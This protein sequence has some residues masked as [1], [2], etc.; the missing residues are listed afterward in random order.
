ME[1]AWYVRGM[2][3]RA[4]PS[5]DDG[6]LVLLDAMLTGNPSDAIVRSEA[7]GQ[8]ELCESESLPS[9]WC[10]YREPSPEHDALLTGLGF[11]LGEPFP[12]DPLFRPCKLPE[13]WRI[14]PT[15]H[16]M[17]SDIVDPR[18]FARFGVFY[19]A[20]F[21]DRRAH[22]SWNRRLT[23]TYDPRRDFSE[24]HY[25]AVYAMLPN[26]ERGCRRACI[27]QSWADPSELPADRDDS[28]A[29]Q[30]HYAKGDALDLKA[31]AWITEH[32]PEHQNPLAY[33]DVEMQGDVHVWEPGR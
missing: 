25:R 15:E 22:L 13:G 2:T 33:W 11:E 16:H 20:A 6:K 27:L 23:A 10:S 26:D 14:R 12:D 17:H 32:Y 3:E 5:K 9:F 18:G 7:R 21:Y 28:A 8:R 19:K 31:K 29:L 24:H 30:A 1:H 4:K